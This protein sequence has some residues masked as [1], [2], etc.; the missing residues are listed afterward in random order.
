MGQELWSPHWI[1][2]SSHAGD[3]LMLN[4]VRGQ[5]NKKSEGGRFQRR[6][7]VPYKQLGLETGRR[8]EGKW[9]SLGLGG[10]N[11]AL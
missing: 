5:I 6:V 2:E 4:W 8:L 1:R 3:T 10:K 9:T 7:K 11:L